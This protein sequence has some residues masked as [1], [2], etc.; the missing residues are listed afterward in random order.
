MY[1]IGFIQ[2][3]NRS[4]PSEEPKWYPIA[5]CDIVLLISEELHNIV[6]T[7]TMLHQLIYLSCIQTNMEND[8]QKLQSLISFLR[9]DNLFSGDIILISE[10]FVTTEGCLDGSQVLY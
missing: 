8:T 6:S 3:C 2:V 7:Y 1:F 4:V 5:P 10:V 9:K